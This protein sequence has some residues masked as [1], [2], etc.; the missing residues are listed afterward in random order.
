[1]PDA[2][3]QPA[4][5]PAAR[6][7]IRSRSSRPAGNAEFLRSSSSHIPT[8]RGQTKA[9]ASHFFSELS[10]RR[11]RRITS[12]SLPTGAGSRNPPAGNDDARGRRA[13]LRQLHEI[14]KLQLALGD[15]LGPDRDLLAVLPLEHEACHRAGTRLDAMG[16][17]VV[18]AVELDVADRAFEVRL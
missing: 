9:T 14:R 15:R 6:R 8:L 3:Q 5:R 10:P 4:M 18:L 7:P 1:M 13:L 16:E 12:R 2:R 11:R 17:L